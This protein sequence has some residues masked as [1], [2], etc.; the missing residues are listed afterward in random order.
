MVLNLF[1]FKKNFLDLL[2]DSLDTF[3]DICFFRYCK[4]KKLGYNILSLIRYLKL[5]KYI[6]IYIYIYIFL[7]VTPTKSRTAIRTPIL[8]YSKITS[9]LT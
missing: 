6:Y 2:T 7:V 4:K 1:R 5:S 8:L 3:D 9:A